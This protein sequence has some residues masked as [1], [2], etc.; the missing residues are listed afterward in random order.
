MTN[1]EIKQ[2]CLEYDKEKGTWPESEHEGMSLYYY[3]VTGEMDHSDSSMEK[4]WADW[5]KELNET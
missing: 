4:K 1:E 3:I 5:E 2:K